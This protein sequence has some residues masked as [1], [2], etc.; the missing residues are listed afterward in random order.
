MFCTLCAPHQTWTWWMKWG[1][2]LKPLK[3]VFFFLQFIT[4][5]STKQKNIICELFKLEF[6]CINCTITVM[7]MNLFCDC[8]DSSC[9]RE[10]FLETWLISNDLD[11]REVFVCREVKLR[12]GL[13]TGNT[14]MQWISQYHFIYMQF[15]FREF[16][17]G[18]IN[19]ICDLLSV[20]TRHHFDSSPDCNKK[21]VYEAKHSEIQSKNVQHIF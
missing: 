5:L 1:L 19:S 20:T 15:L 21:R 8:G 6:M 9:K 2:I 11:Y 13:Q 3:T 14:R 10:E 7:N 17:L 12:K 16:K 18:F 4:I